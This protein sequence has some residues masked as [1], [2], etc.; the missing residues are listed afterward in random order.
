LPLYGLGFLCALRFLVQNPHAARS[1]V[2]PL[3]QYLTDSKATAYTSYTVRHRSR[4]W[5]RAGVPLAGASVLTPR[6]G[7][8]KKGLVQRGRGGLAKYAVASGN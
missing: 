1:S 8:M 6:E 2:G 4:T 3:S 7:S 5:Q